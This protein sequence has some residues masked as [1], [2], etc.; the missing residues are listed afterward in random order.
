[1]REWGDEDESWHERRGKFFS[2]PGSLIGK[3]TKT[4]LLS[5]QGYILTQFTIILFLQFHFLPQDKF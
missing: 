2:G 3:D 1:M 5:K 4:T